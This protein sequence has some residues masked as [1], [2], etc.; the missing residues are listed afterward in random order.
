V[1]F[2]GARRTFP[3]VTRHHK[4]I[5]ETFIAV[6]ESSGWACASHNAAEKTAAFGLRVRLA[7][8]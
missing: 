5:A 6:S 2:P 8:S 7:V 3:R 4:A 1:S